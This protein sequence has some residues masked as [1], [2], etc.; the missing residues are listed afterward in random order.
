MKTPTPLSQVQDLQQRWPDQNLASLFLGLRKIYESVV[1]AE[2]KQV[3]SSSVS[4]QKAFQKICRWV[5]ESLIEGV[6][7]GRSCRK[8]LRAERLA[9]HFLVLDIKRTYGRYDWL[10]S[11][12]SLL[13]MLMHLSWSKTGTPQLVNRRRPQRPFSTYPNSPVVGKIAAEA[14][15]SHLFHQ[16]IPVTCDRSACANR[17]A[18]RALDFRILDPSMESGQLLLE[19]AISCVRR[20]ESVHPPGSNSARRLTRALLKK[21]CA[22]CLWGVDRN[23]L[24]VPSAGLLFSLLGA[25]YGIER[26]APAHLATAD[27]LAGFHQT[28]LDQF[29]GI[30]NNPPWGDVTQ[31]AERKRLRENF[32]TIDHWLDMYVPFSELGIRCLRPGGALALIIPS[33]VVAMRYTARLRGL[34]LNKIKLDQ[35]IFLPRAAFVDATVRAVMILGRAKTANVESGRCRV[36]AYPMEKRIDF[37]GPVRIFNVSQAALNRVGQDSWAP[38][39]NGDG[40]SGFKAKTVRLDQLAS[41]ESGIQVYGKN[42]GWPPQAAETVRRHP[43]T[44]SQPAEGAVPVVRGRDVQD[45]RLAQPQQFV[46][47]GKWLAWTGKHET[48]RWTTRI[49]VRELHRRDGKLTAAISRDGLIPLKGVLT[50]IP[51]GV[52]LYVLLGVLNSMMAAHYVRQHGASFSKVDFQRITVDELG[53]MPIPIA[54]IGPPYRNVLNLNSSTKEESRLRNHLISLVRQLAESASLSASR[55]EKLQGKVENAVIAMYNLAEDNGNA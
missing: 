23:T 22:D 49:F 41:V 7:P 13:A 48:L 28:K 4:I 15:A 2:M 36:T 27:S 3:T 55:K 34:L 26:L 46:K 50:L 5:E 54:A 10:Q 8:A 38:L 31:P 53:L 17:Y 39:L 9:L 16:P 14:L 11:I 42:R 33:Q 21:L 12:A 44:F 37:V 1:R 45:F 6:E 40:W 18:D 20:V 19:F 24:A 43:F 25:E 32:D 29:D 35:L 30:I 52:N 47:F 51:K